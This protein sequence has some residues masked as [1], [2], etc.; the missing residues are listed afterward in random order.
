MSNTY[1]TPPLLVDP[2]RLTSGLTV[3]ST[4]LSRLGDMQNYAFAY[5]GCGDVV[6][7]AWSSEAFEF[8]STSMTDVCQWYIPHPSEEHIEFK[9]RLSAYTSV[10]GSQ[11]K[12]TITFPTTSNSYTSTI[13]ITD[14]SRFNSAFDVATVTLG[15]VEADERAILTLSLQASAG[16]TIEVAA[17]Q[18]SWSPLASPLAARALD[19]Y[20]EEFIPFGAT[21]LGADYPLPARFGVDSINNL[22]HLRKRGRT[23]LNW[24]GVF[25][26]SSTPAPAKGLGVSDAELLSSEVAIPGGLNVVGLKIIILINAVNITTSKVFDIM[27][28]PIT[29][30]SNG[31]SAHERDIRSP[32]L[33]RSQDFKLSMYRVGLDSTPLNQSN[34]LSISNPLSGSPEYI[35]GLSIIGV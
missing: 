31:W 33:E 28:Y 21:R 27:G 9:F 25:S 26:S 29:V 2:A 5:G 18:G 15:A 13:T 3:R 32:E 11:A 6:N 23:L 22:G 8:N 34:L 19:Q 24:S 30:S 16:A 20:E 17:I 10:A 4:E 12:V 7:Q 14:T 35:Q 1:T